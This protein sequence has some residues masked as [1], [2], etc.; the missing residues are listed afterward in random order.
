MKILSLSKKDTKPTFNEVII[1]AQ[2]KRNAAMEV[3]ISSRNQ[4]LDANTAI[5]KT[6]LEVAE[7]IYDLH[8]TKKLLE[9][10]KEFNDK[11]IENIG[12]IIE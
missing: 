10:N 7:V 8:E 1:K 12:K 3:F 4:L 11:L 5:E 9:E 2:Q 6:S